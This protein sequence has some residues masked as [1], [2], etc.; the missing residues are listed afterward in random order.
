[1][2]MADES[3]LLRKYAESCCVVP[4][5]RQRVIENRRRL[6]ITAEGMAATPVCQEQFAEDVD[7]A[8]VLSVCK[9]KNQ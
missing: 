3:D 9:L 5:R 7:S 6:K 4:A 2:K 1:M 8:A